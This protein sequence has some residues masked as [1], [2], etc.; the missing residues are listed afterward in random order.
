MSAVKLYSILKKMYVAVALAFWPCACM[1]PLWMDGGGWYLLGV[2]LYFLVMIPLFLL[3]GYLSYLELGACVGR[4]CDGK[5]RPRGERALGWITT[6]ISVVLIL[7]TVSMLITD[8]PPALSSVRFILY[9][10]LFITLPILWIVGAVKFKKRLHLKELLHPKGV[11]MTALILV[12]LC[13][14][15]GLLYRH[16]GELGYAYSRSH[17]WYNVRDPLA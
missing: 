17:G 5:E 16:L 4:L 3:P 9:V 10:I 7:F 11:W 14:A 1:L 13:L 8:L 12:L 6:A 2:A 15:C